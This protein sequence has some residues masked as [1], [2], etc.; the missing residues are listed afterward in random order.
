[1]LHGQARRMLWCRPGTPRAAIRSLLL[2]LLLGEQAMSIVLNESRGRGYGASNYTDAADA[3]SATRQRWRALRSDARMRS[4]RQQSARCLPVGAASACKATR[5]W[6][7]CSRCLMSTKDDGQL[8]STPTSLRCSGRGTRP[9][10]MRGYVYA[11]GV[12]T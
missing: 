7:T 6:A 9:R 5:A 8:E 1:M 4:N 2:L 12:K 10:C 11:A 3:C